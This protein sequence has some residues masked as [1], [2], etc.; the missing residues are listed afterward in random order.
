MKSVDSSKML[1][2]I[3]WF[4]KEGNACF[5]ALQFYIRLERAKTGLFTRITRFFCSII[6]G[7]ILRGLAV[8][9]YTKARGKQ[10][11][12]GEFNLSTAD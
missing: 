9:R 12:N 11:D 10:L 3:F 6:A 2:T 5:D 8:V 1:P 4:T 7:I